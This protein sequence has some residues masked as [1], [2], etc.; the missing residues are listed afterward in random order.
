MLSTITAA[1]TQ[2]RHEDGRRRK[3]I[4]LLASIRERRAAETR[5]AEHAAVVP[6][7]W[8]ATARASWPRPIGVASATPAGAACVA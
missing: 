3:E 8:R 4:A 6:A 1:E 7:A 2:F 5:A